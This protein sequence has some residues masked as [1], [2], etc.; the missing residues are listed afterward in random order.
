MK[1]DVV[2]FGGQIW[3]A[4]VAILAEKPGGSDQ[5]RLAVRRGKDL[6]YGKAPT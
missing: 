3:I 1:G 5:W 6:R 4:K 2:S